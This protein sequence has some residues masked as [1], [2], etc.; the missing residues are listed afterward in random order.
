MDRRYIIALM[1]LLAAASGLALALFGGR[2][3]RIAIMLFAVYGAMSLPIYGLSLAH[4]NDWIPREDFVEA[5]ATLLLV[6]ALASVAGPILAAIITSHT[7][8]AAL[9]LFAAGIHVAHVLFVGWRITTRQAPEEEF[10]EPYAPVSHQVSPV[11]L[12]LDPRGPD[13]EDPVI[14]DEDAGAEASAPAL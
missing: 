14:L 7:T 5:S 12:E 9:F 11:A 6:N 8:T 13:T 4:A 2:D 3:H 10:R 1:S